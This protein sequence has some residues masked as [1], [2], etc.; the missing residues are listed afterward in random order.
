MGET[1]NENK[2]TKVLL[3]STSLPVNA[4]KSV[5]GITNSTVTATATSTAHGYS[6]GN[7]IL[8]AGSDQPQYNGPFQITATTTNTLSYTMSAAPSGSSAGT[9]TVQL[10]LGPTNLWGVT[11][12]TPTGSPA[13]IGGLPTALYGSEV[14]VRITNAATAPTT[15]AAA[16]IYESDTGATGTWRLYRIVVGSS[17]NATDQI[18]RILLGTPQF[19]LV[20]FYGNAGT[21]VVVEAWGNE[22]TNAGSTP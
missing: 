15:V 19:I 11:G 14:I 18:T 9:V 5:S 10:V 6:V 12:T 2:V 4:S 3:A 16:L 20:I 17:V 22:I 21:A 7:W 1:I 8:M 13:S